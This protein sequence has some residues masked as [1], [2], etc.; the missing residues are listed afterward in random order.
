M[1]YEEAAS[2]K[3]GGGWGAPAPVKPGESEEIFRVRDAGLE[4]PRGRVGGKLLPDVQRCQSGTPVKVGNEDQLIG[5][6]SVHPGFGAL[7][8]YQQQTIDHTDGRP[9][10]VQPSFID[11]PSFISPLLHW[12]T[13]SVTDGRPPRSRC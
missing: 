12:N 2:N 4:E 6:K 3:R 11:P 13:L 9:E 7:H 5:F 1:I 10:L 8:Q